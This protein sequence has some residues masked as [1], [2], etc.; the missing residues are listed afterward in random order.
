L[1]GLQVG[2]INVNIASTVPVLPFVN[3]GF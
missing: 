3:I 1:S 2:I